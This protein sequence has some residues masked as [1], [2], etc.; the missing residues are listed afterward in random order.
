MQIFFRCRPSSGIVENF[1]FVFSQIECSLRWRPSHQWP[2]L[3]INFF[4]LPCESQNAT[5]DH[6]R[7]R[8]KHLLCTKKQSKKSKSTS[9]RSEQHH[10]TSR[11]TSQLFFSKSTTS[12]PVSVQHVVGDLQQAEK[13]DPGGREV[14]SR[15][16][17]P[18][19]PPLW[20]PSF[21][22]SSE[23]LPYS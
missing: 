20:A 14:K 6:N 10:T 3:W 17:L 18:E 16:A 22:P 13:A 12:L 8:R 1:L 19:Q 4:C 7:R 9:R 2:R 11:Q 23:W 21:L 15:R 5:P